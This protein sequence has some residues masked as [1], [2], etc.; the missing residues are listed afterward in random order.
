[1][2]RNSCPL[3]YAEEPMPRK[4]GTYGNQRNGHEAWQKSGAEDGTD[5]K[6]GSDE[7][8]VPVCRNESGPPALRRPLRV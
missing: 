2:P 1:M 5:N 8:L 7:C 4:G 3:L 6:D